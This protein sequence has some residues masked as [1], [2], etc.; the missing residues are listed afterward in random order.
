MKTLLDQDPAGLIAK[1]ERCKD[2]PPLSVQIDLMCQVWNSEACSGEEEFNILSCHMNRRVGRNE[3]GHWH[4]FD[5][6]E[7]A[8]RT[9]LF[10]ECLRD[11]KRPGIHAWLEAKYAYAAKLGRPTPVAAGDSSLF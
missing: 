9:Q 8:Y 2:S 5:Q 10:E 1:A 7:L 3:F 6:L 4:F 11:A